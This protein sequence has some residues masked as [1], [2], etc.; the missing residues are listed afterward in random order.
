MFYDLTAGRSGVLRHFTACELSARRYSRQSCRTS[1]D[2]CPAK[3]HTRHAVSGAIL[4]NDLAAV[5]I[6][7]DGQFPV[8]L[9]GLTDRL[10][11]RRVAVEQQKSTA[12]RAADLA[13]RGARA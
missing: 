3:S 10:V 11:V 9:H 2:A 1:V 12:A 5:R 7:R 8:G 13:A 6:E 4:K